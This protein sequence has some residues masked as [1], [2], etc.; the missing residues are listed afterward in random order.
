[1]NNT[2]R[3]YITLD[4]CD[5]IVSSFNDL[6]FEVLMIEG[7]LLDNFFI[8]TDRTIRLFNYKP[9]KYVIINAL[10]RN[11]WASDLELV[12][13]DDEQLASEWLSDYD[14][15]IRELDEY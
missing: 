6:E 14:E 13:T 10:Y 1:M 7:A 4:T 9:R 11:P 3:M 12:L 8:E 2:V 15:Y 5:K